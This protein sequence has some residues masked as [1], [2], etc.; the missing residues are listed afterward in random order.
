[1]KRLFQI[2][3]FVFFIGIISAVADEYLET[4]RLEET[5]DSVSSVLPVIVI[6]AE[7]A[8]FELELYDNAAAR[9]LIKQFPQKLVMTRLGDGGYYG[10]LR[11]KINV[12]GL[13]TRRAYKPGGGRFVDQRKRAVSVFR[14]DSGQSGNRYADDGFRRRRFGALEIFFG[15]GPTAGRCRNVASDKKINRYSAVLSGT[16]VYSGSVKMAISSSLTAAA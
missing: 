11:E 10:V 6:T 16:S 3:F 1:M 13:P 5:N 15:S 9:R 14:S 8:V 12:T 7:N 4:A 2:L